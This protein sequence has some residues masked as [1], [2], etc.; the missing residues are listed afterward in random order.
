MAAMTHIGPDDIGR[1]V[2][3][4]IGVAIGDNRNLAWRL[5]TREMW[6]RA[7]RAAPDVG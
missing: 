7:H 3:G 4:T 1:L 2:D 5:L 6:S